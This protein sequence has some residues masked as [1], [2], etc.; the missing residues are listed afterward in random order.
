MSKKLTEELP[1]KKLERKEAEYLYSLEPDEEL[2][3]EQFARSKDLSQDILMTNL[4]RVYD[5]PSQRFIADTVAPV[6]G[7]RSRQGSWKTRG[8]EA[9]DITV[10]DHGSDKGET[11]EIS[12]AVGEGTYTTTIRKLKTFVS[13]AEIEE[14]G[15]FD[16]VQEAVLDLKHAI[17][18][19]QEVRVR[20]L[21]DAT[22]NGVTIGTDWDTGNVHLDVMQNVNLFEAQ[23]GLSPTHI[24][25][26]SHVAREILA[27]ASIDMGVFTATNIPKGTDAVSLIDVGVFPSRPWGLMPLIP[28]AMYNSS[29][30]PE[31]VT[32]TRVW[33]DDAF[34]VYIDPGSRSS[35]WAVQ[36]ELLKPTIVRWYDT[37]RGGWYYKIIAKRTE[38]EV[39]AD[40]MYKMADVT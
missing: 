22:G 6:K 11:H 5:Y 9:L 17:D 27:N 33:G 2:G 30:D 32:V 36:Q 13:D 40:A 24:I 14:R 16:P 26:P 29:V 4:V 34:L 18:L 8:Q 19:R 7:V 37:D 35:N 21:A 25:I 10:S 23:L 31:V 20:N 3:P 1:G 28:N 15:A 38:N 12:R 39:M